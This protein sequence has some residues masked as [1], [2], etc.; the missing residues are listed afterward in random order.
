MEYLAGLAL[1]LVGMPAAAITY[2]LA[3]KLGTYARLKAEQDFKRKE[4]KSDGEQT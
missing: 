4:G 3:V 1:I 2:Y